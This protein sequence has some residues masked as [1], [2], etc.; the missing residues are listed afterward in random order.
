MIFT[1]ERCKEGRK[2]NI[3]IV[4]GIWKAEGDAARIS[5]INANEYKAIAKI[6]LYKDNI[7][8]SYHPDSNIYVQ[9]TLAKCAYKELKNFEKFPLWR[10]WFFV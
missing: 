5:L 10:V 3:L 1:L 6:I 7:Y 4:L 2:S 9:I 8:S